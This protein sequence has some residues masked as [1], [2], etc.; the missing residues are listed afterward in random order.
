MATTS[1]S[2]RRSRWLLR[3]VDQ[4]TSARIEFPLLEAFEPS[5]PLDLAPEGTVHES[6][7]YSVLLL[8]NDPSVHAQHA[9]WSVCGEDPLDL[10]LNPVLNAGIEIAGECFYPYQLLP[11]GNDRWFPFSM[12]YGFAS[13]ELRFEDAQG[14]ICALS[15]KD[16][17]CICDRQDQE[18]SITAILETLTGN[19]DSDVFSWMLKRSGT[20]GSASSGEGL[21]GQSTIADGSESLQAF[22]ALS[23]EC[24]RVFD[25]NLG[26]LCTHAFSRTVKKDVIAKPAEVKSFGRRELL[27]L[28]SNANVLY[29][30]AKE[31]SLRL[32]GSYYIASHVQTESAR[33]TYDN[34]ENRAIL[35]FADEV[36]NSLTNV[37]EAAQSGVGRLRQMEETLAAFEHQSGLIPALV[38]IRTCLAREEPLVVRATQLRQKARRIAKSLTRELPQVMRV[39]YRLPKRS[40]P[41]QEIPAYIEMHRIMRRWDAFG[42]FQMLRDGLA[43]G[44]WRMDKLY[45]YY[46]LYA[47]LSTLHDAGFEP[48]RDCAEPFTSTPYSL[49]SRYFA[50]EEQVAT[51]YQLARGSEKVSLYYQPVFYGD[52]TEENGIDIHRTSVTA[53]GYESYWTPDFLLVYEQGEGENPQKKRIVFDAKFRRISAVAGDGSDNAAMDCMSHCLRK[54]RIESCASDGRAPDALW[55]LCGRVTCREIRRIQESS[56][57]L[58]NTRILPDGMA[59]AAPPSERTRRRLCPAWHRESL[60]PTATRP[61]RWDPWG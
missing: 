58:A 38:V 6:H 39:R 19:G 50:N 54:Y 4:K 8:S 1:T 23:E 34:R 28:A 35:A 52:E 22:L 44:T 43:L 37:I 2:R 5:S 57:A 16:I 11:E 9:L 18:E 46:T 13:V 61:R 7:P 26:Y 20:T 45:E 60:S 41:F 31:T 56:W 14:R 27:W 32:N 24:L 48:D 59:S 49:Q 29:P 42:S 53:Y 21:A 36:A 30:T 17:A 3:L 15:T 12:T 33:R 25:D 51:R 47:L 10:S 40:K 55:L